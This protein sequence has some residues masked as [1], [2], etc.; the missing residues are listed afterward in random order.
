MWQ[1]QKLKIV[2]GI[3]LLVVIIWLG[4]LRDF[5]FV[6]IN[7][8]IDRLYYNLEVVYYHSF[9]SFLEPLDVSGLMTLKWL[10]TIVFTLVN[11]LLSVFILKLLFNN[12]K[13]PLKLLYI[14]YLL[15]FIIAGL[16]YLAGKVG[17]FPELGYTLSR[18]F[19]GTIQSPVPL[20]VV[21]AAHMLFYKTTAK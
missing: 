2:A 20:M 19:M 1:T 21:A 14:S 3:F 5:I 13:M 9:Y 16:F 6:N 11:L 4:F 7:Y 18:R 15:I 12:P 17:G 10:L 8:I